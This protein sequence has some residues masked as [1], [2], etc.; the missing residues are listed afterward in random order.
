V[1]GWAMALVVELVVST[2]AILIV[3]AT[4]QSLS[5]N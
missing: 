2:I 1:G 4:V 3:A 5:C